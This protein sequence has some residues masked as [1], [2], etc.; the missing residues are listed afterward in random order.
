MIRI[1]YIKI[2]IQ[3]RNLIIGQV[4]PKILILKINH[5]VILVKYFRI[6]N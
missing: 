4:N 1:K 5:K 3:H 6:L 2:R